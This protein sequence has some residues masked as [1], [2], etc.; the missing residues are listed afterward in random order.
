MI[1]KSLFVKISRCISAKC[2]H[3]YEHKI[4]M[5]AARAQK[6]QITLPKIS[7]KERQIN[8]NRKFYKNWKKMAARGERTKI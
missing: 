5:A 1:A 8:E 3:A 6:Y 2:K 7:R 4:K